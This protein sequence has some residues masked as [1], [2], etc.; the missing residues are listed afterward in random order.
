[1][2]NRDPMP[3][4]IRLT[5]CCLAMTDSCLCAIEGYRTH[6][7]REAVNILHQVVN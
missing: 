3:P 1:M 5:Y 7:I 6:P 2:G 4:K